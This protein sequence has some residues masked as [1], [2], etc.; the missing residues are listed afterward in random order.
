[1]KPRFLAD[2]EL[3]RRI[4]LATRRHEAGID[5]QEA[6]DWINRLAWLPL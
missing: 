4:L 3:D 1:M 5:F 6:T 2:A